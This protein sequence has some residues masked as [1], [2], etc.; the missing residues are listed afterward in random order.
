MIPL[1]SFCLPAKLRQREMTIWWCHKLDKNIYLHSS[2]SRKV[3]FPSFK[4][5]VPIQ[6][7]GFLSAS[8]LK[9]ANP[10]HHWGDTEQKFTQELGTETMEEPNWLAC[11]LGWL[12]DSFL[13]QLRTAWPENGATYSGLDHRTSIIKTFPPPPADIPISQSYLFNPLNETPF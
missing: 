5:K 3:V 4:T 11:F 9:H 12:L 13:I 6:C 7:S 2:H 1:S 8:L 10:K